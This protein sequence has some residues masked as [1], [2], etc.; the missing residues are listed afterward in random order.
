MH[1]ATISGAIRLFTL[2]TACREM[3][4]QETRCSLRS[5]SG[6]F[7]KPFGLPCRARSQPCPSSPGPHRCQLRHPMELQLWK[8]FVQTCP[9]T[10]TSSSYLHLLHPCPSSGGSRGN[11]KQEGN[12]NLVLV[13]SL[14]QGWWLW[15]LTHNKEMTGMAGDSGRKKQEWDDVPWYGLMLSY[16]HLQRWSWGYFCDKGEVND[17][18]PPA[19]VGQLLL[20]FALRLIMLCTPPPSWPLPLRLPR[21]AV[22]DDLCRFNP[23]KC[24]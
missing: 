2:W 15:S 20:I 3:L 24:V 18:K 7:W 12:P 19:L 13:L 6:L 14:S 1:F 11:S 17:E 4:E 10:A 9:R 21:F 22:K 8:E 16:S 23:G 5:E